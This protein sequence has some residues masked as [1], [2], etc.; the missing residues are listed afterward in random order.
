MAAAD[1][2][3]DLHCR[4]LQNS[5]RAFAKTSPRARNLAIHRRAR[6][7]LTQRYMRAGAVLLSIWSGLNLVLAVGIL[8]AMTAFG[9]N[10]PALSLALAESQVRALEAQLIGL[11]NALA[12]LTNACIAGFC[13]LVLVVVWRGLVRGAPWCWSALCAT[14][15]GVQAFGFVSDAHL[16]SHNLVANLVSTLLLVSGLAL[17][18]RSE[19]QKVVS[20][21]EWSDSSGLPN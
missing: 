5:T 3:C 14:T 15:G 9:R 8:V 19:G 20:P 12:V 13:A 4:L 18:R 17:T 7:L 11:I 1:I 16:G 6:R 21:G 10:A 2:R